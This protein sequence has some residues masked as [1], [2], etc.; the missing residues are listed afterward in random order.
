MDPSK[1]ESCLAPLAIRGETSQPQIQDSQFSSRA[2]RRSV[3]NFGSGIAPGIVL[4]GDEAF[5][6]LGER[7]TEM[8]VIEQAYQGLVSKMS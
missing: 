3:R 1:C 8:V 6:P 5:K 7:W 4:Y 2:P